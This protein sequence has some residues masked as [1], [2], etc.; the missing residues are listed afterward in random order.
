MAGENRLGAAMEVVSPDVRAGELV[1]YRIINTGTVDLICG[2]P[3]RLE[4]QTD[5]V[6]LPMNAGMPFR[7]IGF[8][9]S[10]GHYRELQ[11]RVPNDAPTGLYR[12][13]ASVGSDHVSGRVEVS[14]HFSVTRES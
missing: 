14:A 1:P 11:A 8:G 7:L 9:V 12:L 2:L 4:R 10:P 13:I 6:W 5:N 3:Y